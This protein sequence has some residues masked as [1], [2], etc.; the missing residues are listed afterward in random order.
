[1]NWNILDRLAGHFLAPNERRLY[2]RG[3]SR[4]SGWNPGSLSPQKVGSAACHVGA[5]DSRHGCF[6]GIAPD[7]SRCPPSLG[8]TCRAES[9]HHRGSASLVHDPGSTAA[10]VPP[11]QLGPAAFQP[12][13]GLSRNCLPGWSG[14]LHRASAGGTFF[15]T[16]SYARCATGRAGAAEAF[17]FGGG[18]GRIL[19]L[20]NRC[21]CVPVTAGLARMRVILPSRGRDGRRER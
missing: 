21:A 12:G 3:G 11:V 10:S 17:R 16:A 20:R 18:L 14:G 15:C 7:H 13:A 19:R 4:D 8:S 6:A 9:N 5:G 2:T 1:M